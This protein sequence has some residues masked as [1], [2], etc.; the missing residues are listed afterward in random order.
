MSHTGGAVIR[1]SKGVSL[2]YSEGASI[3]YRALRIFQKRGGY[4]VQLNFSGYFFSIFF[5]V[6]ITF[7]CEIIGSIRYNGKI[8]EK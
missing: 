7:I 8:S 1:Y 6:I 4:K 5:Q 2:R 3:G